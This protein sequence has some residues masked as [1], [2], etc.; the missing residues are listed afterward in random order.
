MLDLLKSFLGKS[1]EDVLVYGVVDTNDEPADFIPF[2]DYVFIV[3][4]GVS[5]R[6]WRDE[7]TVRLSASITDEAPLSCE[8]EDGHLP[9]RSSIGRYVLADPKSAHNQI[10]RLAL[11]GIAGETFA[12]LEIQLMSGQM[13]FFDP[14]FIDGI[15][16]G[17]QEQKAIWL[18][19][20]EQVDTTI[21]E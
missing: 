15:N 20:T 18:A 6:L 12:A 21:I 8:L 16:F 9:C 17:G 7:G 14:W 10:E 1:L 3:I 5:I 13:L 11:Y 2:L 4:D 19:N